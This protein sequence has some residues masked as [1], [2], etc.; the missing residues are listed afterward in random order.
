MSDDTIRLV[1]V[2]RL[3]RR[4][5]RLLTVL[6]VLGALAGYGTSALLPA[7]YTTSAS[8]L[9]PGAWE[10]RELLTQAQVATSSVVLDRVAAGLGGTGAGGGGLRERV[11]AEAADGNIVRIS[12]TAGT[13]EGAQRLADLVAREFVG[14]AARIVGDDADPEAAARLQALRQTVTRTAR[15]VTELAEAAG[16]GTSVESVQTR[17]ELAKL[18]TSLQEAMDKLEQAAPSAGK[19]NMVVMGAAARPKDE[20]PPTRTQLVAAGALLFFLLAV[21]GHLAAARVSRRLRTEPEVAAALGAPPLGT[22]DVPDER[23][24]SGPEGG[25]L[26]A[27]LRRLLG[28]DVRWEVPVPYA[29]GGEAGLL[30]RH[31]RVCARLRDRSPGPEGLLVVVPEGDATA[32]RAAGRLAAEA[33]SAAAAGDGCPPLRVV[34]VPVD[35]PMV[36]DR[37]DESGALVVLGAGAWT[38]AEIG[39]IAEACAD[40]GHELVGVVLAGPVRTR[41]ARSARR[42]AAVPARPSG[43][44]TVEAAR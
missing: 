22:L 3:I 26:G 40:A 30:V 18:H 33:A 20:T 12:G 4:R 6:A 8:V 14:F 39:G 42:G 17:T 23:S 27:R 43:D 32:R 28:L 37:A 11:R 10:E 15:R 21:V 31:R 35:R 19:A 29:S 24:A 38:A 36:A 5:G 9:L 25:G 16:P 34:E 13:P 44:E 1:T 41:P 2:G 7:R